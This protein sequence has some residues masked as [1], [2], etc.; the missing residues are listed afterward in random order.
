MI[1]IMVMMTSLM[2]MMMTAL[3]AMMMM[4]MGQSADREVKQS[5]GRQTAGGESGRRP[6]IGIQFQ[7]RDSA[8]PNQINIYIL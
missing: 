2:A 7:I 3:M 8:H 5:H 4:I 6:K 1:M